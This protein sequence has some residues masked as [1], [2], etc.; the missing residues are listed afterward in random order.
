MTDQIKLSWTHIQGGEQKSHQ[1]TSIPGNEQAHAPYNF[2][3]LNADIATYPAQT[4]G[5]VDHSRFDDTRHSG[6]ITATIESQTPIFIGSDK[7]GVFFNPQGTPVIPGSTLRGML[8]QL[9]STISY[10]KFTQFDTDR[11]LFTR[12]MAD[13]DVEFRKWYNDQLV[14]RASEN[15]FGEYTASA[16]YLY[17]EGH[18]YFITP[19]VK[20]GAGKQFQSVKKVDVQKNLG[21]PLRDFSYQSEPKGNGFFIA[22]GPMAG[23]MRDWHIFAPDHHANPV[24]VPRDSIEDYKKDTKDASS[25]RTGTAKQLDLLTWLKEGC[26]G[27]R[28]PNGIPIF[29]TVREGGYVSFGHTALFRIAFEKTLGDHV[30]EAHK[31]PSLIDVT[32]NLFGR[33]EKSAKK[34]ELPAFAGK[35]FIHDAI[36][37][38][39]QHQLAETE[40]L[41]AGPRLTSFQ[42]YLVQLKHNKNGKFHWDKDIFIRGTKLYWH[43]NVGTPV[44]GNGNQNMLTKI[45]PLNSGST[46]QFQLR[47]ENLTDFELGALL[48][49][50][51]LKEGLAHKIGMGKPYGYGSVKFKKI[52]LALLQPKQRYRTIFNEDNFNLGMEDQPF[53][54]H[55][56]FTDSFQ[57]SVF[58]A[59][60]QNEK[61]QAKH[62]WELYRMRQLAALMTFSKDQQISDK[63]SYMGHPR[64]YKDRKPLPLATEVGNNSAT[65]AGRQ[66]EQSHRQNTLPQSSNRSTPAPSSQSGPVDPFKFMKQMN[67]PKSRHKKKGR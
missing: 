54:E 23:K 44:T 4:P 59:V 28:F 38:G 12:P 53:E 26:N 46:F 14:S 29:Y 51:K 58:E 36:L 47:F 13:M 15:D 41:L 1:V 43:Q 52:K 5:L 9:V 37:T 21:R 6:T 11:R 45:T 17:K 57:N 40:L 33:I 42:H 65:V 2:V 16:G 64:E 25:A 22:S 50:I 62:F 60:G 8:R 55:A 49:A 30:D 48:T 31:N 18:D 7:K 10:G 63:Y 66:P 34:D 39:E 3:P 56:T 61:V 20:N 27:V 19:A 35:V 32:E 24:P 67:S